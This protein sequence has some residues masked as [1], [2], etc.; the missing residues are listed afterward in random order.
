MFIPTEKLATAFKRTT[1]LSDLEVI[2]ATQTL[3]EEWE[4]C[5]TFKGNSFE[6]F[7]ELCSPYSLNHHVIDTYQDRVTVVFNF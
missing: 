5:I 7:L 1:D 3:L 2:E 4:Y 6:R